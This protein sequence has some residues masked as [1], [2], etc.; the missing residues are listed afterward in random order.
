MAGAAAEAPPPAPTQAPPRDHHPALQFHFPTDTLSESSKQQHKLKTQRENPEILFK[1][2]SLIKGKTFTTNLLF[3]TQHTDVWHTA[4]CQH[5]KHVTKRGICKGRQIYIF[6]DSEKE[7][8]G[9]LLT[10]N[11][12]LNGT[13]MIQGSEA[14]LTQFEETFPSLKSQCETEKTADHSL[15]VPSETHSTQPLHSH[16]TAVE[17]HSPSTVPTASTEPVLNPHLHT[18]VTQ[19]R[20]SVSL[21][22]VELIGLKEHIQ[23]HSSS[24]LDSRALRDQLSQGHHQLQVTVQELRRDIHSLLDDRE[25]LRKELA[26]YKDSAKREL[27]VLQQ[28]L[29]KE[30]SGLR[31]ELHQR[32]TVIQ[33]LTAQLQSQSHPTNT[34]QTEH[35]QPTPNITET[36]PS[37][38]KPANTQTPPPTQKNHTETVSDT[39]TAPHTQAKTLLPEKTPSTPPQDPKPSRSGGSHRDRDADVAILIDSNGKFLEEEKLFP[40]R[41]TSKIWCPRTRDAHRILSNHILGNPSCILIHTGT[42]DL[43]AEQERVGG[44]VCGV[45]QRAAEAFPK[46]KIVIST[47]LPRKD[48]HPATIQRV[49]AEISRGCAL[50]P[51]VHLAHHPSITPHHLHDHVHVNRQTIKTFAKKLK[52]VALG[53]HMNTAHNPTYRG[54]EH[55][56]TQSFY[57][58][59]RSPPT[60]TLPRRPRPGHQLYHRNLPQSPQHT[61]PVRPAPQPPPPR[62]KRHHPEVP[63]APQTQPDRGATETPLPQN[64]SPQQQRSYADAL[65]GAHCT[66]DMGCRCCV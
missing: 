55:P 15:T 49:N 11:L 18:T 48:F 10:V 24:S 3:H 44:L 32:D 14:A 6:E 65:R 51:N 60:H 17:D 43:R 30:L 5:Y 16:T 20:D 34:T 35:I 1:D 19:L 58:P 66:T 64:H 26:E 54:G 52:D 29:K 33:S 28:E 57:T 61:P 4:I 8:D 41:S 7:P 38:T 42:N 2:C 27:E 21:L 47:L 50:I 39:A 22:E 25:A 31:Q 13:V 62:A 45:A 53:R 36:A 56:A 46:A 23:T 9:K 59:T 37:P 63:P 12:Y 40:D